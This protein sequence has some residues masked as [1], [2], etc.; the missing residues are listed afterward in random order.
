MLGKVYTVLYW[1]GILIFS[2]LALVQAIHILLWILG[3]RTY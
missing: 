3:D 1:V 2:Y